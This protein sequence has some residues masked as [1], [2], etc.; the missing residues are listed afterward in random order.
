MAL[1]EWHEGFADGSQRDRWT[2]VS[3]PGPHDTRGATGR[4][5]RA[6]PLPA[7]L[8]RLPIPAHAAG[9]PLPTKSKKDRSGCDQAAATAQR[10]GLRRPLGKGSNSC[11][12]FCSS[13]IWKPWDLGDLARG[14]QVLIHTIFNS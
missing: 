3:T 10:A 6:V 4:R 5:M 13:L 12:K 1:K 11:N 14:S 7:L 8:H 9:C 2:A